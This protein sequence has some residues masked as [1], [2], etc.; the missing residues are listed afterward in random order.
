MCPPGPAHSAGQWQLR[1]QTG[2]LNPH[3]I[4]PYQRAG[5]LF[6]V[7]VMSSL[8]QA[9]PGAGTRAPR[10]SRLVGTPLALTFMAEFTSLTSF[11][12]L[13]SVLPMRAAA[14]GASSAAAGLI[15]AALLAGTVIAEAAAAFAIRRLGYRVVLAAG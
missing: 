12:L 4:G 8:T 6:T 15:T 2:L 1:A 5:S 11:L 7:V 14:A 3:G 13:I 10:R 9:G